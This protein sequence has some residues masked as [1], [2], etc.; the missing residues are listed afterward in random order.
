MGDEKSYEDR[1]IAD[2][3]ALGF[4]VVRG[5]WPDVLILNGE[6]RWLMFAEIKTLQD[7]I[8]PSQE[9]MLTA[10]EGTPIP[11][12]VITPKTFADIVKEL[13]PRQRQRRTPRKPR[14]PEITEREM[15][16]AVMRLPSY[17]TGRL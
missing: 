12:R 17:P 16:E 5:G 14:L 10:L 1:V 8:R 9:R 4:Q 15:A 6:G 13:Q 3:Q 2:L 11:V 7:H